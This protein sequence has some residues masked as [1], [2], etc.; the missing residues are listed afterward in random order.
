MRPSSDKVDPSV[1]FEFILFSFFVGHFSRHPF[2]AF[3]GQIR[4]WAMM[5]VR[6]GIHTDACLQK[7]QARYRHLGFYIQS[8][9]SQIQELSMTNDKLWGR[10]CG[11]LRPVRSIG[12]SRI[13]GRVYGVYG[14]ITVILFTEVMYYK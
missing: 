1:L 5:S 7:L 2:H 13:D 14:R 3:F 8:A 10:A 6:G 9:G 11:V 12:V 4:S